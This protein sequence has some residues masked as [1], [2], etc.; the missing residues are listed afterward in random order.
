MTFQIHALPEAPFVPLFSMSDE[1]LSNQNA[2]RVVVESKPGTPCRVSL[3]DAEVG[4]TAILLNFEHQPNNTPYKASHAIFVR[5]GVEQA[6]LAPGEIPEVLRIRLMSVRAFDS[7][8]QMIEADVVEGRELE[9][10]IEHMFEQPNIA[11][12]HLHNA[13]QGCFAASVTRVS[14]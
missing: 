8:H 14:S 12:V 2:R 11:Y 5:K 1:D 7:A 10:I 4:E 9:G 3:A 13:K 6:R